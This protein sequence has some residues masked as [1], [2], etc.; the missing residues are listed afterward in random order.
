MQPPLA[1]IFQPLVN[2]FEAILKFFHDDIGLGWGLAIIALTVLIRSLLL[3]LTLKQL[4]SMYRMAQFT[5]EIRKLRDKHGSDPRRLQRETMAFYRENRINPLGSLL[6]AVAQLPVFLSV[7]FMLRTDLR[8][9]ICPGVQPARHVAPA[10][11]RGDGGVAVP[12][13]PRCDQSRHGRRARRADCAL[14]RLA[15]LLVPALGE[16]DDGQDATD[17]RHRAALLVHHDRVESAGRPARVLDHHE[18]VD[19][20]PRGGRAQAPGS[21]APS[22]AGGAGGR[23]PTWQAW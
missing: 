7:Y 18:H 11:V 23:G 10:V 6:P 17:D 22:G 19:D 8:H 4:R 12:L 3:P 9:D 2:V 15:A 20:R 5:P 14:S 1:N 16:P 21:P 13:H